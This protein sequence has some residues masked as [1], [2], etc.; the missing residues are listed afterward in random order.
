MKQFIR[1]EFK[2]EVE[3]KSNNYG[4]FLVEPL[5]R[6]FGIT[7]GNALRRTL[8]SST[9]GAAVF[10]IRIKGAS[11][12]FTAI[13]GIVEHV[14]KIILNIKNLVLKIDQNIIPDGESV[15]LK[16]NSNK[17]GDVLAKD[18]EL[19]A[20]VEVINTDL[21]IATIAKGGELNL[22]LHARNSRGYKSFNDNKK[23]KKYADLIVIDSNYSPV[24]KVSYTVEP[25]KVGK[26]ADLEKLE[27]EV[28]TDSSITPVNAIAMAGKILSEHLEFF[29]NLNEAI[30][31]TQ[32]ISSETEKEE[33]EL[34]RSID[35]LEFTQR[36]QN[37]LKRAKIETLRD[38]ISKT[39]EEI[40]EIRNLGKKSLTEIKE[41]VAALGL[42]FRRD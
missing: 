31:T 22:E 40:Q 16:I 10:A 30:K 32:V 19:P 4:K 24:Q 5:E 25:T 27:I 13:P 23:E 14:T 42:Y 7:L 36:S 8:L 26:N 17:E 9:P 39:E 2:L 34:D 20:G 18:I 28:Q 35:E 29:I 41:K 21:H 38:L 1:P 33:D 37:C 15:I 6:G 3:D 11:H 12:E